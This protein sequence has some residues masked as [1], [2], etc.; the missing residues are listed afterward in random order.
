MPQGTPASSKA[1]LQSER[2]LQVMIVNYL[3]QHGIEPL[4]HR[5]DKRSAATVGWPDL[6]LSIQQGLRTFPLLIEVK[7]PQGR[8]SKDQI[9]MREKLTTEP[10]CWFYFVV[11]SLEEVQQILRKFGVS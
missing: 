3:R 10:N 6:T 5:M 4:W 8:L 11:T 1:E 2:K 9:L 7:L